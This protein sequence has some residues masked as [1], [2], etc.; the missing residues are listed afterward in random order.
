MHPFLARVDVDV[1]SKD[2]DGR[3]PLLYAAQNCNSEKVCLFLARGD[4]D[5]NS[6]DKDG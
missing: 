3:S 6:K 1:N 4:V 5:V 2:K